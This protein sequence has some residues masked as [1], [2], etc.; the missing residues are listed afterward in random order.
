MTEAAII[1]WE[2]DVGAPFVE[3]ISDVGTDSN[4]RRLMSTFMLEAAISFLA[5]VAEVKFLEAAS[6]PEAVVRP[7]SR[8]LKRMPGFC[9]AADSIPAVVAEASG[10]EANAAVSILADVAVSG[11]SEVAFDGERSGKK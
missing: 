4:F 3:A 9:L 6:P 7:H 1:S 10:V 5:A 11:L 8:G 2:A